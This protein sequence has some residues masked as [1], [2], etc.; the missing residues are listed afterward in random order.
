MRSRKSSAAVS[1]DPLQSRALELVGMICHD[2]RTPAC[3]IAG[4]ADLLLDYG[5][6]PLTVDQRASLERIR[7]N[8]HFMLDLVASMM[9]MVRLENGQVKL[10][11]RR[12]DL[13]DLVREA[14][15]SAMIVAN[16]K[17]IIVV[18][19]PVEGPLDSMV[20][21]ERMTQV[22]GNLLSN[23]IKFSRP[24]TT[25]QI[26]VRRVGK[27]HEIWVRDEGPG[28]PAAEQKHLFEKFGRTTVRPTAGEKSGGL[29]LYI[30]KEIVGL[31]GGT[32]KVESSHSAGS[33]FRV[34]LP[35]LEKLRD[36][37][38]DTLPRQ[39]LP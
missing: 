7:K 19:E 38:V 5:K 27:Q 35:A 2:L 34:C 22:L 31:H 28:I 10:E 30:V 15:E 1:I 17:Q 6:T 26:G 18:R 16:A 9:D 14:A 39:M 37:L 20:D 33:T 29:G 12:I 13:C 23:A 11:P 24:G 4:F 3:T 21:H 32:V 8:A 36:P 25:V